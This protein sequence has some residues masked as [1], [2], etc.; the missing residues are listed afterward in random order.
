MVV[1]DGQG[2][3]VTIDAV[4]IIPKTITV[5]GW[6][7]EVL[8]RTTLANTAYKTKQVATLKEVSD[9][10][11]TKE[12]DPADLNDVSEDNVEIV[13]TFPTGGTVTFWGTAS[14]WSEP[15]VGVD[16]ELEHSLTITPTNLNDAGTETGPVYTGS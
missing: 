6:A 1:V 14:Q 8:S 13:I 11:I 5:P 4:A 10:A 15:E 3:T 12:Y 16:G 2:T 7:K 9:F